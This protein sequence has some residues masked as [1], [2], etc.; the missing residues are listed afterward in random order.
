M[1]D[2]VWL[3]KHLALKL[4]ARILFK[5]FDVESDVAYRDYRKFRSD[6][7]ILPAPDATPAR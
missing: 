6:V 4:D 7:R 1:N 3:P 5:G 2:E